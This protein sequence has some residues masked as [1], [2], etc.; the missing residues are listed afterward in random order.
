[1]RNVLAMILAGG[2]GDNLL[3]LSRVRA[4]ASVPFAGHYRLIDFA[5][6]NCTHSGITNVG[7]LTQYLPASLKAH[8]GIGKPWDLD[9]RDGGVRLL[10]P[11]YR[12]GELRWY[13]GTGDA[14][15][16]NVRPRQRRD[17]V[18]RRRPVP[19]RFTRLYRPIRLRPA[20]SGR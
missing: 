11:Y 9:R 12:G 16:Q 6:S 7:V 10:E 5:L 2:K 8:I 18:R 1:M 20:L 4:T 15:A 3:A 17:G 13:R 19:R 14:L